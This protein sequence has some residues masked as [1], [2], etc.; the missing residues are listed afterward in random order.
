MHVTHIHG[1]HHPFHSSMAKEMDM[2]PL[3]DS[4]QKPHN[5]NLHQHCFEFLVM[6]QQLVISVSILGW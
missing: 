4:G 3:F 2:G 5:T 1:A 6:G